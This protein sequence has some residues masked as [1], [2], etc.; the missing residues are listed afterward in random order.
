MVQ[1]VTISQ[2]MVDSSRRNIK[3]REPMKMRLLGKRWYSNFS[4]EG[5]KQQF[6]LNAWGGTMENPPNQAFIELGELMSDLKRGLCP[7]GVR[8]KIKDIKVAKPTKREADDLRLHIYPFFGEYTWVEVDKDLVEKYFE[9]RWG[10]NSRGELQA[11]S[12]VDKELRALARVME[13]VDSNWKKPKIKHGKILKETLDP[14]TYDQIVL[15]LT[16][17][18][19]Q[20]HGVFWVMAYTAMDI[21]DVLALTPKHFKD[22]WIF[23][24]RGKTGQDIAVPVCD[25][26]KDILRNTPYPLDK[27]MRIFPDINDKSVSSAVRRAFSQVGLNG[28]GSK[29]LRR[30]V[31]SMLFDDGYS[32]DWIGKAL[33][34]AEGSKMTPKYTKIYKETLSKAFAKL[35]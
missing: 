28:Y 10:L 15:A 17:L 5:K 13:V 18:P 29:Y 27:N 31:A 32:H 30:Y 7:G 12:T 1:K 24:E 11:P 35:G 3:E 19:V 33:A 23:K 20:H 34:H 9:K 26:L 21:S 16:K 22:G 14:L 8:R 2:N 25:S 6:A 4:H